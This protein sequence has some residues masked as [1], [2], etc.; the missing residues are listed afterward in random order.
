MVEVSFK[1]TTKLI[2][3]DILE[4]T[5]DDLIQEYIDEAE[6][7]GATI[8]TLTWANGVVFNHFFFNSSSA[9]DRDALNGIT[10]YSNVTFALKEKFEK[11]IIRKNTTLNFIDDSEIQ[12]YHDLAIAL[13]ERSRYKK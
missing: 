6:V 7:G 1:P 10:H 5:F 11:Q 13:K 9:L 3:H 12:I 4:Y 2:V 8:K